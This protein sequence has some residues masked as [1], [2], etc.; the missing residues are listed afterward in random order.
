MFSA[1]TGELNDATPE[2]ASAVIGRV[3]ADCTKR[4]IDIA[5]FGTQADDGLTA[6]A[7]LLH[8]VIPIT[9]A[10]AGP[11][12]MATDLADLIGSIGNAGIDQ[13]VQYLFVDHAKKH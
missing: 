12:A 4:S 13:A 3:L 2:T 8:G 5:A 1:V 11:D 7:G 6:P 9:A 10:T